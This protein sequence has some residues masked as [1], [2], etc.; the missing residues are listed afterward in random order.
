MS[1]RAY[2]ENGSLSAEA[3]KDQLLQ[4]ELYREIFSR[5][6]EPIAIIDPNGFYV[7]QNAAHFDLLGYSKEE[8]SG[9]TPAAHLGEETFS[10]ILQE[11]SERDEFRG[12]VIS[13]TKAGEVRY[14]EL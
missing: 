1:Q 14:I 7:E 11:L 12:E 5:S 13:R 3:G 2:R 6:T 10:S 4:P 9:T 8:L